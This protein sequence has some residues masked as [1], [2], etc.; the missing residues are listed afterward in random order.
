MSVVVPEHDIQHRQIT[1]PW[2]T[3]ITAAAAGRGGQPW[4]EYPGPVRGDVGCAASG[5]DFHRTDPG[6]E[7]EKLET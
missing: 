7:T 3:N 2:R 6:R 5:P 1:V 4:L